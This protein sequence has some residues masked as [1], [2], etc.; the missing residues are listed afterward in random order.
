VI[1]FTENVPTN[2]HSNF[3]K[4]LANL[5]EDAFQWARSTVEIDASTEENRQVTVPNCGRRI[6][7]EPLRLANVC[8]KARWA[9]AC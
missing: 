3:D 1:A 6:R 8:T 7:R 4:M 2:L 9:S 5:F